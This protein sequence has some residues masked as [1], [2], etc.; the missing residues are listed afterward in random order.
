MGRPVSLLGLPAPGLPEAAGGGVCVI[1]PPIS[2]H[3]QPWAPGSCS[4]EWVGGW[5]R[6][7]S[8]GSGGGLCQHWPA[9]SRRPAHLEAGLLT[10]APGQPP[11]A[12][13]PGLVRQLTPVAPSGLRES[14][15][16]VGAKQAVGAGL[17]PPGTSYRASL[18]GVPIARQ[19]VSARGWHTHCRG[20][21]RLFAPPSCAQP[22][23][24]LKTSFPSTSQENLRGRVG[25]GEGGRRH[26]KCCSP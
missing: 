7:P 24:G 18:V 15:W 17:V 1:V 2:G 13:V 22:C 3:P 14:Q 12:P 4:G 16:P 20:G 11:S 5:P 19:D 21:G 25:E 10:Q 26:P 6:E 23:R 9:G 8:G